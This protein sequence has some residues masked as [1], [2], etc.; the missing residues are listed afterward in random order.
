MMY[1]NDIWLLYKY[2]CDSINESEF[3]IRIIEGLN[4]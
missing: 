4:N 3:L 2:N 1:G